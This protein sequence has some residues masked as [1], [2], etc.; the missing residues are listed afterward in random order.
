MLWARAFAGWKKLLN[1]SGLSR[2]Q[3][4]RPSSNNFGQ[5]FHKLIWSTWLLAKALTYPGSIEFS[6]I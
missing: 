5:F 1:K 2:G 6:F 3:A 4:K